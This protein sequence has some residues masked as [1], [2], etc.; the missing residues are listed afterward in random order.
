MYEK[1]W[2]DSDSQISISMPQMFRVGYFLK[3][4]SLRQDRAVELLKNL[5]ADVA[6]DRTWDDKGLRTTNLRTVELEAQGLEN[7][8]EWKENLRMVL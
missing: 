4:L 3:Y 1:L 6:A 7:F 8:P 2:G 5:C